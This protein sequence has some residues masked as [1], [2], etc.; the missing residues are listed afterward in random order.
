MCQTVL[1]GGFSHESN[2][3]ADKS[4]T[5]SHFAERTEYFGSDVV[6]KLLGTN[7]PIGGVA[8]VA[9]STDIELLPTVAAEAQPGGVV[10]ADAY[11]FYTG[12]ILDRARESAGDIDGIFLSLHGAM[13]AEG[14]DDGEGTLLASLK[15]IVGDVPIVATFD[16]HGNVTQQMLDHGDALLSYETYPH[17]DMAEIAHTGMEL[18]QQ[19]MRGETTPVM[20]A[21]RPPLLPNG[22]MQNTRDG[23]MAD[24]MEQARELEDREHVLKVNVFFGYQKSDIP[25]MGLSVPVITDD[26]PKT[27]KEA[28]SEL[29]TYIWNRR[30]DFVTDYP[31]PDEAISKAKELASDTENG[32]VVL[33][34][35]GDNPGGGSTADGTV[36]LRELLEQSVKNAGVAIIR[37]PE[38]VERCVEAGVGKRVTV[39]LGGKTDDHHG[40]PIDELEGYVKAITDGKFTNTGP[41]R[42]GA[43]NALGRTI[44]FNCGKNDEVT[45]IITQNRL[46]PLD[47]EIW[48]H[49]GVQPEQFDMLVVKSTNHYRADYEPIASTTIPMDTPG[50]NAVD[51]SRFEYDRISRPLFP[52]DELPDDAYPSE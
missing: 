51:P 12:K 19:F 33:A 22:P 43:H 7:T 40:E 24:V 1:I 20:H 38:A 2:M 31:A 46:Q 23:P 47:T 37:D 36:V 21:E 35:T 14:I 41:M 18:L 8:E 42:T 4:T 10:T 30:D 17:V 50:L 27:A 9:R 26:D 28:S 5:R 39:T 44:R 6:E 13:L 32:P 52:L 15:E 11:E 45:V 3:F 48:R 29:A 16:P 25:D 34:D 49:I